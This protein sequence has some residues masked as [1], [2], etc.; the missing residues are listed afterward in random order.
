MV[1]RKD[2]RWQETVTYEVNGRPKT[3]YFYGKTKSEV[4]RKVAEF[5]ITKATL[6]EGPLFS[7]LAEEWWEH[8][9]PT[10]ADTTAKGYKPSL[11][12]AIE[13]LGSVRIRKLRPIDINR[14]ME[15]CVRENNM[16]DKTARAQLM[17]INLICRYAVQVGHIDVNPANELRVP[18][19]LS[20][21]K[22]GSASPE[23][24]AKVKASYD[25]PF[26]DF[27]YW[28]LYTGCRRGELAALTWEDIDMEA[29]TITIDK[30]LYKSATGKMLIKKPKTEAGIRVVPILDK[31][32]EKMI[33]G[34]GP[35]FNKD[36][37]YLSDGQ[38]INWWDRYQRLAGVKCTPHQLRH[39]YATMLF[40]AGIDAKDAQYLLGHA[41]LSTTMDI[42][43]DIRE[44]R[45]KSIHQ[46]LRD[47]DIA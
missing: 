4:T 17:V 23:D 45:R 44:Q 31:L 35:V 11:A 43:T 16:A 37:K 38:L 29:R 1:K 9:E 7:D 24:I 19:G 34:K 26:G 18:R 2:G 6:E 32:Y 22:R 25:L 8:H 40:E 3:K 42:Y 46:K 14:F 12:R 39:S 5:D 10:L 33:P 21:V 20:H 41:Q 13:G 28:A 27:A 30:A 47:I 36:G 15:T